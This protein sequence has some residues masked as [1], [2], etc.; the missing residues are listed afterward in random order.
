[1]MVGSLLA[2]NPLASFR[3]VPKLEQWESEGLSA[4][5]RR[6]R[7]P[8]IHK[9]Y[10]RERNVREPIWIRKKCAIWA[11]WRRSRSRQKRQLPEGPQ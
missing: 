2:M 7:L 3:S 11:R 4:G 1:M 5:M 8:T 10:S 9:T 6:K